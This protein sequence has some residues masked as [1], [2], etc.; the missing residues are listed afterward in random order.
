LL[1]SVRHPPAHKRQPSSPVARL[2]LRVRSSLPGISP[3][4]IGGMVGLRVLAMG[5]SF[6]AGILT[7]RELGPH[8]RALLALM[9]AVPALFGVIGV[10][11]LDNANARFAGMSHTAFRQ[12]VGWAVVFSAGA[13]T[14]LAAAWWLAGLRW[15]VLFVGLSPR[16]AL[17]SA[18][19]CPVSLLVNLLGTA[20]IGRGRVGAYNLAMAA[21]TVGYLAG[22][23]AL[24][25]AGHVT[26]TGCFV[27]CAGGQVLGTVL[28]LAMATVRAQPDGERVPV[29]RYLGYAL[30]A[31]LPNIGH[32][33]MLRMDVPVIS[34]M[35]GTAAVALYAVALPLAECLMVIPVAVALVIFPG[36]TSGA[37]DHARANRIGRTVMLIT[38]VLAAGLGL[39]AP[40]L[41]PVVYGV[42]YRGSVAVVWSMLPGMVFFSAAR[43]RQAY[44]AATDRLR[45]GIMATAAGAAVGLAGLMALTTRFGAAGAGLADSASYLVFAV[46]LVG[47][48]AWKGVLARQAA[49]GLAAGQ[50]VLRAWVP[51]AARALR[52][53]AAGC[54]AVAAGLG[55]GLV[56]I[57]GILHLTTLAG[58]LILVVMVVIP[59]TGLYLLA[60]LV[61]VSQTSFGSSLIT[62]KDLAILIGGCLAGRLAAGRVVRR[63]YWSAALAVSLVG[64]FVL[65]ATLSSGSS[66]NW[67]Y[68]LM[69]GVPLLGLPLIADGGAS[70]RR[71]VTLLG[72]SAAVLAVPEIF[73][74]HASL[75]ASGDVSAVQSAMLA[76]GQTGAVNH[77]SEGALFVLALAVL[78]ARYPQVRGRAAR[79]VLLAAIALL[80]VGVAYSFSRSSYFGAL[81]VIVVF[82]VRRS[83][84]GLIGA[85]VGVGGLLPLLPA[86]VTARLG[87]VWSSS[88]L[89]ADSAVRL[90]LWS[91]SIRMFEVHP[92][93]GVGYLNFAA[94][95]PAYFTATGNYDSFL[96]QLSLL[97]FSHNTFLTVLSQTGI[98][99]V[100][101]V[102]A[103]G[104]IG[105]RRGWRAMRA[106]DWAGESTVL[107]FVGVGMCSVFGEVLLVPTILA[108]F[109]M[110]VLA[111]DGARA[112][113]R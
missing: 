28:L 55:V 40:V 23:L 64:Y 46:V 44:L 86:A 60:V 96:I 106:A 53:T 54:T 16:L 38:V 68:V 110:V 83:V 29:R 93:F 42:P 98:V 4:I 49:A 101:L 26:L 107:A 7:A 75:A 113:G 61:P 9:M 57:H 5:V 21:T 51:A 19:L 22:V 66:D 63:G 91:S 85:A 13:G 84:R 112:G 65:S 103:L 11:G 6:G 33:G 70:T 25:A 82:A 108:A 62:A 74:S 59:D 27:S 47:A 37:V 95:L 17:Y 56:S 3:V 41:I 89:D 24:L 18:A 81:A 90:D 69:L 12:L 45:P 77:N 79:T 14:A 72:L 104:T 32:Y 109:L 100:L 48:R 99:G 73:R 39:A 20:E 10:F 2:Q 15:P 34:I 71:A 97:D 94:Q 92:L 76:A 36:V 87:T 80:V 111:A 52:P 43:T 1:T 30:R 102:A 35:A 88:G 50:Q 78:L 67:R 105:W 58:V 8:G 31:Y